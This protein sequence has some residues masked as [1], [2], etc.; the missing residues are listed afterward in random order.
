MPSIAT[1]VN[2]ANRELLLIGVSGDG[3]TASI[4]ERLA[5]AGIEP[6]SRFAR[7]MMA[8]NTTELRGVFEDAIGRV[9]DG[10]TSGARSL[11]G[12]FGLPL[13]GSE[14]HHVSETGAG[15]T[16]TDGG[17]WESPGLE[18]EPGQGEAQSET[19]AEDGDGAPADGATGW[20]LMIQMKEAETGAPPE[21]LAGHGETG[22]EE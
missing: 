21:G 15:A 10:D 11:F 3:D 19:D 8:G 22:S 5:A 20:E 17:T 14:E 6:D 2:A 13:P 9:K 18:S 16:A 7:A 4:G 1:G 12:F